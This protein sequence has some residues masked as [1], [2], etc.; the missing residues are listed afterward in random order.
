MLPDFCAPVVE[1]LL[2]SGTC[3]FHSLMSRYFI[4]Y[5]LWIIGYV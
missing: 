4:Y 1:E 5:G 3:P 2:T